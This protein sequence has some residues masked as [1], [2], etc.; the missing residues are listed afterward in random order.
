MDTAQEALSRPTSKSLTDR[1]SGLNTPMSSDSPGQ[2]RSR[3]SNEESSDR[4]SALPT[5]PGFRLRVSVASTVMACGTPSRPRRVRQRGGSTWESGA[6]GATEEESWARPA[7]SGARR[8]P[9]RCSESM[10]CDASATRRVRV[11]DL[12]SGRCAHRPPRRCRG[13][14]ECCKATTPAAPPAPRAPRTRARG[15]AAGIS[16]NSNAQR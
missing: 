11:H 2:G 8:G 9:S 14:S 6:A 3:C 12:S 13:A 1:P 10:P 15:G 7:G 16:H 5:R 4:S